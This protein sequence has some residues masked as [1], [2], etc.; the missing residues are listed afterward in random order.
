MYFVSL[1]KKKAPRV[2]NDG[3][4]KEWKNFSMKEVIQKNINIVFWRD[5]KTKKILNPS[6]LVTSILFCAIQFEAQHFFME[7]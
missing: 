6:V 3:S 5:P 2:K 1:D 7:N 4:S